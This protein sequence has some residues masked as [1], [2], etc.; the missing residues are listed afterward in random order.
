[1]GAKEF[2]TVVVP[3]FQSPGTLGNLAARIAQ[4]MSSL[5]VAW[6][7]LL[8]VDGDGPDLWASYCDE[9]SSLAENLPVRAICLSRNVGQ[10]RALRYGIRTARDGYILLMDCDLQDPPEVIPQVLGPVIRG[11][12]DVVLTSRRGRYE[13]LRRS[14]LRNGYAKVLAAATG[15]RFEQSLGPVI[16]LSPSARRHLNQFS[17]DAHVLHLLQWLDM[18][19][20]V[21]EYERQV[22]TVGCSSYSFGARIKHAVRGLAFSS[23]RLVA[24][25]FTLSFGMAVLAVIGLVLLA[26]EMLKGSPPSGWLSI[27]SVMVLGFAMTGIL[28]SL[29][30]GILLE[31]LS[32]VRD[33]PLAVVARSWPNGGKS[34]Y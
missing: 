22:R 24:A 13:R 11:D 27:I 32:L 29:I 28:L 7:L 25:A 19:H 1:M 5:G 30:G 20:A 21:F 18:P 26:V 31:V 6:E 15:M 10:H 17:E 4:Q 9:L 23:T 33:R 12:V 2:A 16:A 14:A 34:V 8:I 3:V